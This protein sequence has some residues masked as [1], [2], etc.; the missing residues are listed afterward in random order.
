MKKVCLL[1]ICLF[2]LSFILTGCDN[3]PWINMVD[4]LMQGDYIKANKQYE[5]IEKNYV[6][7]MNTSEYVYQYIENIVASFKQDKTSYETAEKKLNLF[8]L[9][10]MPL[11]NLEDA[12]SEVERIQASRT[13]YNQARELYLAELYYDAHNKF[14][15]VEID[16]S[17][18]YDKAQEYLLSIVYVLLY[19]EEYYK[20]ADVI[21]SVDINSN[22]VPKLA[23]YSV[24]LAIRLLYYKDD[25]DRAYELNDKLIKL[26]IRME[27]GVKD[28]IKEWSRKLESIY[29]RPEY[30]AVC[31]SF[32][33]DDMED[34]FY[35]LE[36]TDLRLETQKTDYAFIILKSIPVRQDTIGYIAPRMTEILYQYISQGKPDY[37]QSVV[38]II[39]SEIDDDR[40][41]KSLVT[42]IQDNI[43]NKEYLNKI[44]MTVGK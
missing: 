32:L 6:Y 23:E 5:K 27:P 11:Y 25:M 17:R 7:A 36:Q 38:D 4:T 9:L 14:K 13:A 28:A 19:R 2:I 26:L 39:F 34:M 31:I 15:L 16:D 24:D 43:K 21:L 18:N 8:S 41:V 22:T 40:M 3:Q 33:S 12:K 10:E 20:A 29:S 30:A 37:A 1:I 44:D 42:Y 35:K